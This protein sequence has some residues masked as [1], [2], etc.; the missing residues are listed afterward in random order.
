MV[1]FF[2]FFAGVYF[3]LPL[4]YFIIGFIALLLDEKEGK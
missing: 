4:G 1:A 3:D 2:A